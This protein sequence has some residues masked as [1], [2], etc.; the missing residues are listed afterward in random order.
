MNRLYLVLACLFFGLLN[1][2]LFYNQQWG[3]NIILFEVPLLTIFVIFN[4]T[5]LK[6]NL[7]KLI[8]LFT[9]LSMINIVVTH[10][11]FSVVMHCLFFTALG[12][13]T[14]GEI[15]NPFYVFSAL[16]RNLEHY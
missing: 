2:V 5:L 7:S 4:K 11:V 10:T 1:T 15:K 9:I 13:L 16:L 12:G 6:G 3:L 8:L 14:L